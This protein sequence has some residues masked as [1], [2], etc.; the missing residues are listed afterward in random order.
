MSTA[1]PLLTM[2]LGAA[3]GI[4]DIAS[5]Q[6]PYFLR[7]PALIAA[8]LLAA[9]GW[10][11]F[12]TEQEREVA[13][14]AVEEDAEPDPLDEPVPASVGAGGAVSANPGAAGHRR[15][16]RRV[17]VVGAK[18]KESPAVAWSVI[19]LSVWL[20][21]GTLM[22]PTAPKLLLGLSLLAA[23]LLFTAGWQMIRKGS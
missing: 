9:Q 19:G 1:L 12:E 7:I 13:R 2:A 21:L 5:P 3:L 16:P 14:R 4:Q 20:G 17:V 10:V 8:L 11:D 18:A 22:Y 6:A 15:L 23:F